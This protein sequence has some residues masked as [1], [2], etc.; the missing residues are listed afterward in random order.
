[1]RA[2]DPATPIIFSSR[3]AFEADRERGIEAGADA[4]VQA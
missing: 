4:Y 3:A 1:M 2:L